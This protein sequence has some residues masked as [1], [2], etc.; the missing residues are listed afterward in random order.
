MYKQYTNK[1]SIKKRRGLFW[2]YLNIFKHITQIVTE[3]KE[4]CKVYLFFVRK[5]GKRAV[6]DYRYNILTYNTKVLFVKASLFYL[7]S[8]RKVNCKNPIPLI[9]PSPQ[10]KLINKSYDD[11]VKLTKIEMDPF[12]LG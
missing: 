3:G 2:Y 6:K 9:N 4:E 7:N 10:I 12:R 5:W 8:I 11:S 1:L